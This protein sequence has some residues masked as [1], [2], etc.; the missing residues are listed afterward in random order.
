MGLKCLTDLKYQLFAFLITSFVFSTIIIK[1]IE[2]V[3]GFS[4]YYLSGMLSALI[5]SAIFIRLTGRAILWK[6]SMIFGI[7]LFIVRGIMDYSSYLSVSGTIDIS[8][9]NQSFLLF[10]YYG[11][12]IL[13][14]RLISGI[15]MKLLNTDMEIKE[16]SA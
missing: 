14:L 13:F 16:E 7:I 9:A 6:E 4:G 3:F 11:L 1:L 10:L 8:L 2:K 5:F 15:F 12:D